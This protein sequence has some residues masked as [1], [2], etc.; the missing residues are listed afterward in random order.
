MANM[1]HVFHTILL[2]G[3][4]VIWLG[5]AYKSSKNMTMFVEYFFTMKLLC[6]G[7]ALSMYVQMKE[8]RL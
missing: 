1:T 3:L 6:H 2:I 4:F 8:S 7:H 5:N